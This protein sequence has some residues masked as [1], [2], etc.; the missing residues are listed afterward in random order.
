MEHDAPNGTPWRIDPDE[1][2]ATGLLGDQLRF[3]VRYAVLA[4]SSH[5]T[6]PWLFRVGEDRIDLL[7]DESRWLRVADD[8]Q[9]ELFVSVGC[10]LENLLVAAE[11]FGLGHDVAYLPNASNELHTATVRLVENG[12]PSGFRPAELFEAITVR[13]TNH[14]TYEDRAIPEGVLDRLR[15]LCF[16][17]DLVLHLTDDA[18]IK[19]KVDDLVVRGDAIE[20]ADPAFREEL[21]YW[22]GQGVFGTS[23]LMSKLGM[24]AVTHMNIGKSQ[25]KKDSEVLMSSPILGV[26][27]SQMNDR[28]TQVK[29]GQLYERLA[30]LSASLGIWTQPMSQILQVP[31][32]KEEVARLIPE[33]GLTPLHPFRMGYADPENQ[34]TPRRP[35]GEVIRQ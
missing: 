6:Q 4:P 34:H 21:G 7:C 31:E 20:L 17:D 10:A 25:A 14:Q 28:T 27:S 3:L 12:K 32:L 16:E 13:H 29:A 15:S 5:N 1:Y 19:R 24:L 18:E 35:V 30:L 9:R 2:P 22:I 33:S 8:D 26:I 23:W 11:H